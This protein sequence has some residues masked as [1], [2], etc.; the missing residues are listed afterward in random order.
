M[1]KWAIL[2]VVVLMALL[3]GLQQLSKRN[4]DNGAMPAV[5]A[6][7]AEQTGVSLPPEAAEAGRPP[8]GS[9]YPAGA[10][11]ADIFSVQGTSV[12][13]EGGSINDILEARG[14]TWGPKADAAHSP[15]LSAA[16]TEKMSL[17]LSKYV[18]CEAFAGRD[19][20]LCGYA[21][22]EMKARGYTSK[23]C[24]DALND[25]LAM[26]YMT[27]KRDDIAACAWILSDAMEDWPDSG[28]KNLSTGDFCPVAAKGMENICAGVPSIS[29][30]DCPK[31][32]PA[33]KSDCGGDKDCLENLALYTAI[34]TADAGK[35][36]GENAEYCKMY[37]GKS[38]C[39]TLAS[40]ASKEY[41][42]GLAKATKNSL[43][44]IKERA[45]AQ[46]LK[47]LEKAEQEKLL[48]QINKEIKSITGKK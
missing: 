35:C 34:K 47:D 8:L 37:F 38:S 13:C 6:P 23:E 44:A 18:A 46:R 43:A 3:L 16:D 1:K 48:Q 17:D 2:V 19:Q 30:K 14:K 11:G 7:S 4:K 45:E 22:E 33:V 24:S 10:M 36:G 20:S 40:S 9:Q 12:A 21:P 27:G 41:C 42:S 31:I 32:F 26:E 29:R 5:P 15:V 25:F 28:L 39:K